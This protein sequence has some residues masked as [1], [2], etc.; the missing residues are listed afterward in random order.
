MI[1]MHPAVFAGVAA[2]LFTSSVSAQDT[3]TADAE[4]EVLQPIGV[5]AVDEWNF[6]EFVM[7]PGET[8]SIEFQPNGSIICSR[9][10]YCGGTQ[11]PGTFLASGSANATFQISSPGN[12]NLSDGAG[13]LMEVINVQF[14]GTDVTVQSYFNST[15]FFDTSGERPFTIVG[16]LTVPAD[17]PAG[18]YEGQYDVSVEYN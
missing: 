6:G 12:F 16:V 8:A 3:A 5:V 1:K 10:Q 14:V 11:Q 4:A 9:T 15:S 2:A 13:N 18:L 7:T 17:S